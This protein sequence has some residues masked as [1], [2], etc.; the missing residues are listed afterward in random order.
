MSPLQWAQY[1]ILPKHSSQKTLRDEVKNVFQVHKTQVHMF[2]PWISIGAVFHAQD[3][4]WSYWIQ[5]SVNW[6]TLYS[7]AQVETFSGEVVKCGLKKQWL[8]PQFAN[9]KALF[10]TSTKCCS[11]TSTRTALKT[12]L[13]V[14]LKF[15]FF[16][17]MLKMSWI[18][19]FARCSLMYLSIPSQLTSCTATGP[20]MYPYV[21]IG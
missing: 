20:T 9:S 11:G 19:L 16:G 13:S 6:L 2:F 14:M 7:S 1:P 3:E 4:N 18:R 10:Q 12:S 17:W 21:V 5:A 8:P 15:C